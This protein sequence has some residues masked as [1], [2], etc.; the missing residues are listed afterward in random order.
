MSASELRE[1]V[2]FTNETI[3]RI[4]KEKQPVDRNFLM[5]KLS[6]ETKKQ[7]RNLLS[8]DDV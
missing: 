5:D 2:K 3:V 7:M 4:Y 1:K 6:E 8:E